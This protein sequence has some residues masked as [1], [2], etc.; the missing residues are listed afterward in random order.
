MLQIDKLN[1]LYYQCF[2]DSTNKLN[3]LNDIYYLHKE[4]YFL[5]KD[6]ICS[7]DLMTFFQERNGKLFIKKLEYIRQKNL[8][9]LLNIIFYLHKEG[10]I[11]DMDYLCPADLMT[12]FH[13]GKGKLLVEKWEHVMQKKILVVQ[14]QNF[15]L[16]AN[17]RDTEKETICLLIHLYHETTGQTFSCFSH[18][19]EKKKISV[20]LFN[21][22]N[23]NI[24]IE[25]M[26]D[27]LSK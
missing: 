20:K 19:P 15:E 18:V 8:K 1:T 21:V 6:Y 3:L 24:E 5:D 25:K 7:A 23:G 13:E 14:D 22:F 12:F 2:L 16:A 27:N 17:Y 11:F 4:G 26:I 10:F 9:D